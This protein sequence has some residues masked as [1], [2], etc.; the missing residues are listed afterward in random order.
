[1]D[2]SALW[3]TVRLALITTLLLLII[4]IPLAWW[5]SVTRSRLKTVI[6]TVTALPIVLPPTVMGFYL[7]ILFSPQSTFGQFWLVMT[8]QTLT[9]SFTGL[10]IASVLYSLPF[11]IQPIQSAFEALGQHLQEAAMSLR[12]SPLDAF[13]TVTLPLSLRGILS[14]CVLSFAHTMGEFGIVLM[15]GGNI[16]GETRVISIEIYEQVETLQYQQAHML[17]LILVGSAFLMLLG[18]FLINR[19]FPVRV[20]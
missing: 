19:R 16:P 14:G 18:V 3:L 12:A 4:G 20:G 7:L 11:M 6:E 2:F 10:V 5:L 1:M 13:L 9:F 17:S 8:G 15:V